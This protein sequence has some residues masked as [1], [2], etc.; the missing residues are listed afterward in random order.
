SRSKIMRRAVAVA[1]LF[2]IA[3]PCVLN[4]QSTNASLT[5][6]ITDPSRAV[7]VGARVAAINEETNVRYETTTNGSG[8]YHLA[9]LPPSAYRIEVEKTGF[10]KLVK[11]EVILHVQDAL[12]IDFAMAV[13]STSETV[14][15]EGGAPLVNTEWAT[16]STM[17]DRTA[18]ENLPLNGRS[19]QTLI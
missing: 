17:V 16:V 12:R 1:L 18:V 14:S 2:L 11:P 13:G 7:I 10:S 6:R 4:G 5:G 15:V 9:N 19:F 8:E 3:L